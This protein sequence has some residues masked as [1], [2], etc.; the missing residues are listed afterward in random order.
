VSRGV[1]EGHVAHT[2]DRKQLTLVRYAATMMRIITRVICR[3]AF[4]TRQRDDRVPA[5]IPQLAG[6]TPGVPRLGIPDLAVT[7][8]SLGNTNAGNGRRNPDGTLGSGTAFP[9]GFLM[10]STFNA[11]AARQVSV[12][13]GQEARQRRIRAVAVAVLTNSSWL[14]K[15]LS[16]RSARIR[17]G[18]G[19]DARKLAAQGTRTIWDLISLQ[20][21]GRSAGWH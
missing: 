2:I 20:V 6:W 18:S 8:A 15:L 14:A 5:G 10:G 17:C 11:A 21:G 19:P 3:T 13:L 16:S 12:A 4:R 9:A 1:G 7:D